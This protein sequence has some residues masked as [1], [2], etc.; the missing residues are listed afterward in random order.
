[1]CHYESCESI[2]SPALTPP[3]EG[4]DICREILL[5]CVSIPFTKILFKGNL[6]NAECKAEAHGKVKKGL[7]CKGDI[8]PFVH[9]SSLALLC[10]PLFWTKYG[11]H[12]HP[13]IWVYVY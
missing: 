11:P 3:A 1:M 13:G 5:P 7:W 8:L 4:L 9:H 10:S 2:M 12:Y 6:H